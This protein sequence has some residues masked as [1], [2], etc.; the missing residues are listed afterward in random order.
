MPAAPPDPEKVAMALHL[1]RTRPEMSLRQIAEA[2][3][4]SSPTTASNYIA[5]AEQHEMWMPA[6][7]RATIGARVDIVLSTLMDRL[8]TRLDAPDNPE[9]EKTSRAIV[10]VVREIS[11]RHGLYAPVRTVNEN[12]DA[13]PV[14][15]PQMTAAV[16][17][18]LAELDA[19]ER[20]R[21]PDDDL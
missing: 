1:R 10:E 8:L 15:D 13:P 3:D 20:K 18:A 5:L 12:S 11:K 4:V 14:P 19:A 21:P 17:A 7:N 16:Q 6:V 9:L 2:I